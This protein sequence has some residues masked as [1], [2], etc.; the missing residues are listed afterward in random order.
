MIKII[1]IDSFSGLGGGQHI[2]FEIVNGLRHEFDFLIAAPPGIFLEKYFRLGINIY[3]L[4]ERN[5]IK[6][7]K[8]LR[9]FIKKEKP[10]ILH[11]HGTRAAIWTRLA[12]IGLKNRPKIIYTLHGFHIP[13]RSFFGRMPLIILERFLNR[14]T[15]ILVCVSEADKELVLKYKTIAKNKIFV[16]K[17]GIDIKEFQIEQEL[18]KDKKKELGLEDNFIITTIGRLHPPKD[19]STILKALKLILKKIK[20]VKILII[21]DGHLRKSL[22]KETKKLDLGKN[23]KFLGQREDVPILINLS[24]IIVLSTNWEGLP[25]VPLEAGACKKPVIASNVNG[26]KETIIDGKTGF[27]F[28]KNSPKD[29]A[30]KI[31]KLFESENLRKKMGEDAFYFVSEKFNKKRMI[32]EYKKLYQSTKNETCY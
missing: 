10:E 5:C 22:K 13:R 29:L 3:E 26:V 12:V 24:D 8:E 30:E 25:L 2:L 19:F 6:I 1:Q 32:E 17:N 15:D 14:L 21:G 11:L 18:I 16:I 23:V 4:K 27:L 28:K 9:N 7:I 31:L 20:N